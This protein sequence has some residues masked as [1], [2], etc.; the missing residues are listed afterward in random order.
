M[1]DMQLISNG[2]VWSEL[3]IDELEA[4]RQSRHEHKRW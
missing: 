3:A 4:S 1:R 2:G